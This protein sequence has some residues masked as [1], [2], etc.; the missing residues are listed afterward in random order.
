MCIRDRPDSTEE[1]LQQVFIKANTHVPVGI[2]FF[3]QGSGAKSA[4][5]L[6]EWADIEISLEAFVFANHQTMF[7][8]SGQAYT[9]KLAFSSNTTLDSPGSTSNIIP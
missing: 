9:F 4:T 6:T 3:T 2:K 7:S 5:G 1:S 8:Q